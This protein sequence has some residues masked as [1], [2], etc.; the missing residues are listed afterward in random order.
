MSGFGNLP[1]CRVVGVAMVS[2]AR[3]VL[4]NRSVS[5]QQMGMPV[6]P[7]APEQAVGDKRGRRQ[8]GGERLKHCGTLQPASPLGSVDLSSD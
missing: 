2:V 7:T 4:M 8:Y 1:L 5:A 3:G 6:V